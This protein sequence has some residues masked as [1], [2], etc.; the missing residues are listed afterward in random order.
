[1]SHYASGAQKLPVVCVAM[2]LPMLSPKYPSWG[3]GW[4]QG[5]NLT[6]KHV[7]EGWG[8]TQSFAGGPFQISQIALGMQFLV[9]HAHGLRSPSHPHLSSGAPNFSLTLTGE[10]FKI[11]LFVLQ[12]FLHVF[13]VVV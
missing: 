4:G 13:K 1:M 5:K 7:P 2:C 8:A 12:D 10:L 3:K 6:Y 9:L 11:Y